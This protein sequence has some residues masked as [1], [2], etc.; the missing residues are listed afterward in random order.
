MVI[1]LAALRRAWLPWEIIGK[2]GRVFVGI[3]MVIAE[4]FLEDLPAILAYVSVM[5]RRV[6]DHSLLA[7]RT[8]RH[9]SGRNAGPAKW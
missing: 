4:V 5:K 9:F 2:G 1:R 7:A 6:P 8:F 3:V